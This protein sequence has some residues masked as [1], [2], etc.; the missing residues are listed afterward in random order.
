MA[1][2]ITSYDL[3]PGNG[4]VTIL[5]ERQGMDKRKQVKQMRKEKRER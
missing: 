4:V 2:S 3:R 1:I 5:E